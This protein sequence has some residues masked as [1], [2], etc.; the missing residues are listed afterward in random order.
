[1]A[2]KDIIAEAREAF[3]AAYESE[4]DNRRDAL[5]DIR[6]ARLSE[7][8]DQNVRLQREREGRPCLTINKLTAF[9][10]QV[11]NDARQN[12]P[13]IKVHPVD[14]Q[15]DKRTADVMNGLIRNVEYSSNADVAYDTATEDAVCM[16]WGYFKIDLDYAHNDAFD[17][18]ILIN[19]VSDPFSIYGD[20]DSTAA[21]SSDW[22]SA[23][24]TEWM[25]Q[26]EFEKAFGKEAAKIDWE[27][28]CDGAK[29]REQW[30]K[31]DDVL[32]ARWWQREE[33]TRKILKMS[34]GQVLAADSFDPDLQELMALQG[35]T[36]VGE[37]DSKYFK[38]T[39]RVL[40]G[41][42]EL[43]LDK[44]PGCYIPIVPVY[45]DEVDVEG[46][47]Y[48]R[49]LIR[50]AKDAQRMF[51]YWRTASTE[52]VALSPK[53]PWIGPK[54]AFKTDRNKWSTANTATHQYI[55]YDG[56]MP[57]QRMH[58]DG[59]PAGALQEALNASDDMKSVIGMYDASLGAK[60][61]ET[62]GRAIMAR[63]REGDIATYHFQDN[64]TRAIRHAGRILL[65]LIPKVYKDERIVR[66]IGEDGTPDIVPL[67]RPIPVKDANGQPEVDPQTQ[68]PVTHIYDLAKGK[69][70]L[71]VKAGPS[72]TSRREEA[73]MQM[74]EMIRAYPQGAPLVADLIAKHFDW[75]GADEI[76]ERFKAMLPP[77]AAGGM[78]PELEQAMQESQQTIQ[79]LAA[80]N[81]QLKAD[82]SIDE[83]KLKIDAAKLEVEKAKLAIEQSNLA[84]EQFRAQTERMT[85]AAPIEAQEREHGHVDQSNAMFGALAQAIDNLAQAQVAPKRIVRGPDGRASHTETVIN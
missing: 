47:R 71:V 83:G 9:T 58:F 80:E 64:M 10:R 55:E 77:Q 42:E 69:Y 4:K 73:A 24:E 54:G 74:T 59:P 34:D 1:L 82:H 49:S 56:N 20:P 19:R 57:P 2:E 43:A 35:V 75:P 29:S 38:V 76:A 18:D 6:F 15:A 32:V 23:F 63:Q 78:P 53:A 84:I 51:N 61:N 70:D 50:D 31:G 7:Q 48:F 3:D 41:Q 25:K 33:T 52:L 60:S 13:S 40:T 62:S 81:E 39:R 28:Y 65:D 79:Q 21:D 26:K 85:A 16:G 44:W 8:W 67:K 37:R 36:V 27:S 5:D 12:K 72:F 45:G 46:K 30:V 22:N 68:Q 14:D 17:L 11:V 66:T